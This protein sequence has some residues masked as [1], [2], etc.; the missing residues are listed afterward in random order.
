[1]KSLLQS[2]ILLLFLFFANGVFASDSEEIQYLL[3]FISS[4]NCTF[5]RNGNEHPAAKA[6]EHLEMKY[7]HAK[8]RIHTAEDFIDK[9]A[10]RSSLSRKQYTIRCGTTIL[11]TKQWLEEA[12]KLHRT[13]TEK[14]K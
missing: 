14:N 9:I 13:S 6:R 10:S 12:L 4:S 11:P 2:F 8:R 7:N 3:S 5:I 1:M